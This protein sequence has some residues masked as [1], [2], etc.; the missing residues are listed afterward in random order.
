MAKRDG[1]TIGE[2]EKKSGIRRSTIHHYIWYGLLHQPFRTGQTMAY[3]D[4][5]H[6]RRLETIQKIKV[7]F[8]KSAKTSRVPLDLIKHK[9]TEDY[10]L[11]KGK[12]TAGKEGKGKNREKGP[13]K[14]EGE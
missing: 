3:Y 14:K 10:Q 8:L 5:S 9:L 13:K 12:I 6:L 2:L 1:M 11:T 7:D 4:R